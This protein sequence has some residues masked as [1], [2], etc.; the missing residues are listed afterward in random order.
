MGLNG[1]KLV[2]Y[3]VMRF[4]TASTAYQAQLFLNGSISY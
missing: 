4:V 3:H 2:N 1:V